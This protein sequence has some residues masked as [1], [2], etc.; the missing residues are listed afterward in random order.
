MKVAELRQKLA[1]LKKEEIIK[2][3]VEFYKLIPKAKK[4]INNLDE[5]INNPSQ[6]KPKKATKQALSLS[7]IETAVYQFIEHAREQ[8]YFAPNRVVSKKERSTWRFKVKKWYKELIQTKRP[9]VDIKKQAKILCD[10][11]ELLCE[12]CGYSYFTAYDTFQS[13]GITQAD[14]YKTVLNLIAEAEGKPDLIKKGITLIVNNYLNRYTL[15]TYLMD[16]LI[17]QLTTTDLKY[18]AI[19]KTEQLLKNNNFYAPKEKSWSST[20]EYR[21]KERQNN[22][23]KLGFKL[24]LSL[25]EYD[26]AIAFYQTYYQDTNEEIKLYVLISLL[27]VHQQKDLV[28]REIEQAI[29]KGIE[30]RKN[31]LT[32]LETIKDTGNLPK[33]MR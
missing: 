13:L 27:F 12:S 21:K 9:D 24:H 30:P 29:Q 18:L 19:E 17:Q 14:F 15:Y 5:M 16:E 26:K 6:P 33:Y 32:L 10:L 25:F 11:Y 4:E 31:L 23:A 7:E 2:L 3:S 20:D 8:Y 1:K 28:V 22:L